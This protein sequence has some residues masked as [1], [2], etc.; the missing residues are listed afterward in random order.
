MFD[1]YF[2]KSFDKGFI[3]DESY[4]NLLR[5]IGEEFLSGSSCSF[6]PFF[7]V[8]VIFYA[9]ESGSREMRS[10]GK[11]PPTFRYIGSAERYPNN[12]S[13]HESVGFERFFRRFR[14][15]PFEFHKLGVFSENPFHPTEASSS[16]ERDSMDMT[17]VPK[18]L[19]VNG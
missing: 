2:S 7:I 11:F 6:I 16:F 13:S 9:C 18:I 17:I 12:D 1:F 4:L 10:Y 19:V 14:I 3:V 8:F 15:D 5:I